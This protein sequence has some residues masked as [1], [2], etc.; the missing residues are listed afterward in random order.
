MRLKLLLKRGALLAAANWPTVAIQFAAQTIFQMLLAV[1]IVGAAILVAVFLGTDP[2]HLL[3][4]G[5]RQM[6]ATVT[7][8]LVSEPFALTAF[9]TAFAIVLL[10]GSIFM[11]LVKGGTVDVIIAADAS[12]GS[13]EQ[14]PLTMAV[15]RRGSAFSLPRFVAGCQRLF[16]RYLMLGF[17]L[18]AVYAVTG[19]AYLSFIVYGYRSAGEGG[20]IVGWTLIAGLSAVALVLW[21]TTVNLL[22]LLLQ[23]ATAAEDAPL[24]EAVR[25]VARFVRAALPDL[26]GVFLVVFGMVV[27]ATLASALAWSGVALIAFVPLVGLAV[28]PLQ[29][30]ALLIRGLVF[31]YIGLMAMGSYVALYRREVV[32]RAFAADITASEGQP[33]SAL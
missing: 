22:Y 29:I 28:V 25:D 11:F 24:T 7:D 33:A 18:M 1:P 12:A 14:E 32:Q 3:Q 15:F 30:V 17:V 4:G 9:I 20:F 5:T 26:A 13:I 31:E 6:F 8:A 16:R 23:I 27:A 19:A 2:T 21:I 10:G